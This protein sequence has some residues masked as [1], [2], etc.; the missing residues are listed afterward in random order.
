MKLRVWFW[1]F[2]EKRVDY[3]EGWEI[4]DF[5]S[6]S[7]Q[8]EINTDETAKNWDGKTVVRQRL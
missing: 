2:S 7:P 5:F 4:G 6:P 8:M 1:L 3:Y